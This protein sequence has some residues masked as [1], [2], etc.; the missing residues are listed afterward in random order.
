MKTDL[1]LRSLS[2]AAL[3]AVACSCSSEPAEAARQDGAPKPAPA[4][5][6]AADPVAD[7]PIERYRLDLLHLAWQAASAFPVDPHAKTRAR[8][9]E[10]VVTTCFEVEQPQLALRF[11][12]GIVGWRQGVAHADYAYYCAKRG[13]REPVEKHLSLARQFADDVR[14]DPN[15]QEWRRDTILMKIARAYALLG[16]AGKAAEATALVEPNSGLAVDPAWAETVAAKADLMQAADLARELV[17]MDDV[18]KTAGLGFAFSVL[19]TC[20]R[21]HERFYAD[22]EG[23]AEIERRVIETYTGIPPALRIEVVADMARTA[24]AREDAAHARELLGAARRL[25]EGFA[26]SAEDVVPMFARLAAARARAGEVDEAKADVAAALARYQD[27][28]DGIVD[29]FR[30]EALR[31]LAEACQAM[32]EVQQAA[33]LYALVLEEGME[34]PHS[35]PRAEDIAETCLSMARHAFAPDAR[36][37]ARIREIVNGLGDPW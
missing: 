36:L 1:E 28:R 29:M 10:A 15:P 7:Q 11:A 14:N 8:L 5:A 35:R 16:E 20:A 23:R 26:W 21:L 18:V 3:L 24:V 2:L 19:R 6:A 12:K 27:A 32:G 30:A 22:A 34:N 25:M 9:Q 13:A 4:A 37:L 17:A 31:P 33:G